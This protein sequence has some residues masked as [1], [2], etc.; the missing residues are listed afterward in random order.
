MTGSLQKKNNTYY[1]VVRIPDGSG[2]TKQKWINTGIKITGNNKREANK[3][4]RE[5]IVELEEQKIVCSSDTDLVDW[6]EKWL[7]QK[8][9]EIRLNT[10]EAYQLYVDKHIKP[11]FSPLKLTLSTV[12]P[13]HIQD[14]YT[15]KMDEGL[16]PN[17]IKRY[18]AVLNGALREALKKNLIPYNPM[19]RT[20]R[21]AMRKFE[22]KAYTPDLA[23]KLLSVI[24][25]EPME[26]V[27][28]L[29]LFYGLRRSEVLGLRWQDVNLEEGTMRICN[30]V[31]KFNTQ[32]E[33]EQTKSSASRRTLYLTPE[34]KEYLCTLKR[35][36]AENRK[37]MGRSYTKSDHVCTWA[38]GRSFSPNY[39]SQRFK[40]ILEIHGLPHIRFHELRHTAGS[41]LMER[42]MMVMQVAQF[43]GH[44]KVATT[45][46]IY[47]HLSLEGKKET[48][49]V[50]AEILK[51]P[52]D[53]EC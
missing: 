22:G 11:H 7:E 23:Q 14:F 18:S 46:D 37:L 1:A 9:F 35:R 42:G 3:R 17:S 48:S 2:K 15:K 49:K 52:D 10:W 31:I 38:D 19:E 8:K 53:A 47:G 44:E 26:S 41:M 4:L 33:H 27:I 43:L 6:I 16:N 51:F 24:A 21:P 36:Q 5:I 30:T 28:R 32:I 50:M 40:R 25:D 34:I 12:A 29:A 20:T 39:I 45:L 13:Q